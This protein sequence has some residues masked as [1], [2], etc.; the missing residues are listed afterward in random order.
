MADTD[1]DSWLRERLG[2]PAE[3]LYFAALFSPSSSRAAVSALA[4]L[5]IELEA[6]ATDFRDLNV[7]RT[8]LAWWREEIA[9]LEVQRAEHPLTRALARAGAATPLL[10]LRDVV[11]GAELMLLDG[12]V[13]DLATARIRAEHGLAP[14]TVALADVLLPDEASPERYAPLGV[15]AGLAR[16]LI[17]PLPQ[18]VAT[19]VGQAAHAALRDTAALA[20]EAPPPLRVLAALAWRRAHAGGNFRHNRRHAPL[21]VVTAWRAARGRLPGAL[22]RA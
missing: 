14:L 15:A 18:D 11:T 9:R 2:S 19:G 16:V 10:S 20:R 1:G 5:F 8:K 17:A 21:R 4:A 13:S 7:A 12:P 22:T 3:D 6:I